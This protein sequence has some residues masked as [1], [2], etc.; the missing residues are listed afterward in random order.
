MEGRENTLINRQGLKKAPK[1]YSLDNIFT[2]TNGQFSL[3]RRVHEK[4][5]TVHQLWLRLI[6]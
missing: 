5:S 1:L 4:L 3:R 6:E 2:E